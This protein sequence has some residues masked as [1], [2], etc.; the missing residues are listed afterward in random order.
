MSYLGCSAFRENL[1]VKRERQRSR[2]KRSAGLFVFQRLILYS[3]KT[4]EKATFLLRYPYL[5]ERIFPGN[6]IA[7]FFHCDGNQEHESG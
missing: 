1:S 6:D 4:K 3:S 2:T 5:F 7:R